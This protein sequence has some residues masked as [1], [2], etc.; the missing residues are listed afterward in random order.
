MAG[1]ADLVVKCDPPAIDVCLTLRRNYDYKA[2]ICGGI[3][4]R[5][6]DTGDTRVFQTD[7]FFRSE[8][9]WYFA[10]REGIDFGPFTV[11]GD[12]ERALVRYIDT[13]HTMHKLRARDP[14][15]RLE[16]RWDDQNV[17]EAARQVSDWRL[18]RGT[19]SNTLYS[20]RDSAHK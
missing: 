14:S 3:M 7:R 13:Q 19:R 2:Y 15:M 8:G 12:G 20:D 16:S 17:A 11:R 6:T 1:P 9:M 10:T 4:H 5:A 18:D